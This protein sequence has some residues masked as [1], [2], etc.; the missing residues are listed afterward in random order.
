MNFQVWCYCFAVSIFLIVGA[1]CSA[2]ILCGP[3]WSSRIPLFCEGSCQLLG[4]NCNL[5]HVDCAGFYVA[6]L[7][8][9]VALDLGGVAD[10]L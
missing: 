4:K 9:F 5:K 8:S 3:V 6:T 10:F 1:F 2:F 7:V